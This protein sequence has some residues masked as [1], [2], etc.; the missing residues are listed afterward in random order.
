VNGGRKE[1]N[2]MWYSVGGK[3]WSLEGQ[4]KEEKWKPLEVG[5]LRDPPECTRDLGS[6]RLLG[7]KSRHLNGDAL[8]WGEGMFKA[9]LQQKVRPSSEGWWV[10]I[11]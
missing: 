5:S 6:G 10:A 7:I 3:D 1:G 11:P 4:Q 9:H 8:Q 2:M